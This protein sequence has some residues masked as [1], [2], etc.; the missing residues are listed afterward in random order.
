MNTESLR[1][2]L[3]KITTAIVGGA[4][5]GSAAAYGPQIIDDIDDG[6]AQSTPQ[7][8]D[9][10]SNEEKDE[11]RTESSQLADELEVNNS[12]EP[13]RQLYSC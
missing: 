12:G 8:A 9:F 1:K 5:L 3:S 13:D 10:S 4:L 2:N 11:I 6:F 7:K